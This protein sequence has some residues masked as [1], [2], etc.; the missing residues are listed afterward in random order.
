MKVVSH[1]IVDG[2]IED[3]FGKH[4]E[5]FNENGVPSYSLPLEVVD[6]PAGPVPHWMSSSR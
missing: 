2:V 4:G 5:H 1:G 6:A 3:R